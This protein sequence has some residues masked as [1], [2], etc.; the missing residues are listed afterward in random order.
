LGPNPD[1][2]CS[3]GGYYS[4]LTKAVLCSSSFHTSSIRNV[5]ES[6]KFAV[7]AEYGMAPGHYGSSLEIDHIVPLELGGSNE[8]A[9]LYP[10]KLDAGPGYRVKD[11]LENKAHD[12]VC[13]GAIML[14]AAQVGIATNWQA[15]YKRVFGTQ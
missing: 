4:G 12:L 2:A 15:L 7:E 6:E 11:R 14:H 5:P 13:S 9:N 3:P 10:E 8:I 1:R